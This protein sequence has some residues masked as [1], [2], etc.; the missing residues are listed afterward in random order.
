VAQENLR[1]VEKIPSQTDVLQLVPCNSTGNAAVEVIDSCAWEGHQQR[2][3]ACDDKL[4]FAIVDH[5]LQEAKQGELPHR[6]Q[7]RFGLIEKVETAG[8]EAPLEEGQKALT[9]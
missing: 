4:A 2:R 7:R 3:V 6:R 1:I 5:L 9:M 8:N